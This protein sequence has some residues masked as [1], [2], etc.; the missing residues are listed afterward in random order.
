[1][2]ALALHLFDAAVDKVLLQLEIGD[3]VAQQAAR[4][5]FTLIDM[6][7][8]TRAAQLLCGSHAG[9]TGPDDRDALAGLLLRRIGSDIA[10]LISLVGQG[11]LHR[12]D[13]DGNILKVQRAGFLAGR[14][15]DPSGEFREIVGRMQVADRLFPV[16]AIDEVVPFRNLVMDGTAR[17]AMTVGNAAI[18]AARR[19]F[20]DLL[21]RHGEREFAEMPD[22]VRSRLV[23]V[24]LPVDF[25]KP[26]HLAH[27][28]PRTCVRPA[29]V[30]RRAVVRCG[31]EIR[32][33]PPAF[34]TACT[35]ASISAGAP[36]FER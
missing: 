25:K 11:L 32:S 34:K 33:W 1:A 12:L 6:D 29:A 10:G 28:Y 2:H 9:R 27:G 16:P 31:A 14:R 23:L 4:P 21:V 13:G 30:Y 17:R 15:A 24:H 3:P 7:F 18:H 20:F 8:M 22:S 5:A 36:G 19:L 35:V 26:C